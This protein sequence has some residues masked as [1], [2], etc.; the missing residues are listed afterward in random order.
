MRA[1]ASIVDGGVG[2]NPSCGLHRNL[3]GLGIAG[4]NS[5]SRFLK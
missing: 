2:S 4:G 3:E 1:A 5:P